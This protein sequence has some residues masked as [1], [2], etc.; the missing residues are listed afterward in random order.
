[1]AELASPAQLRVAFLRWAMVCVP[2]V[3]LLGFL[4]GRVAGGGPGNPW[5]EALTKPSLYPP[6]ATFGV[7]WTIL[8]IMMGLALALVIS[9]RGAPW[10]GRAMA[11]FAGQLVLNLAWSPLFFALHQIKLALGLLIVLDIAV[12]LTL[13]AFYRTRPV[14][15]WLLV[16]YLAWALFA[17]ALN[18]QFHLANPDADG[19]R[20]SGA[21]TRIEL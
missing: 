4:S 13:V 14:A 10:R 6:P 1:M 3:L 5:F 16:P 18:L 8:Y 21:A 2:G 17:T 15:G 11:L 9:A 7:V 20:V 19:Q 12:L